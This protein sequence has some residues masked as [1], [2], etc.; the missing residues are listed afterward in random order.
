MN[1][2]ENERKKDDAAI[3]QAEEEERRRRSERV[4]HG[5]EESFPASDPPAT[6][7]PGNGGPDTD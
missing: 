1:E 6:S 5:S 7:Y 3:R 4:N 2:R